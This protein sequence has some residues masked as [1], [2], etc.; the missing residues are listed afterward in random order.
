[1]SYTL[2]GPAVE[3]EGPEGGASILNDTASEEHDKSVLI[4]KN[5]N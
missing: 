5:G 3:G 2:D 1:M 4:S